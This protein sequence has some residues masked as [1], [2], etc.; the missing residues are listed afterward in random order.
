MG[1]TML[2]VN[3][4]SA[5]PLEDRQILVHVHILFPKQNIANQVYFF[6]FLP[7]TTERFFHLAEWPF[8]MW[9]PWLD[10]TLCL[11]KAEELVLVTLLCLV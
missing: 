2:E 11:L 1:T 6:Q 3:D 10:Y 8:Y 9:M 4:Y 5:V 7:T